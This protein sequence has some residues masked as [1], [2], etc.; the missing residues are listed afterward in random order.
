MAPYAYLVAH[1]GP[2]E[3]SGLIADVVLDG[4]GIYLAAGTPDVAIR[5][6]L[7]HASVPGLPV[8]LVSGFAVEVSPEEL[9]ASGVHSVLA[10][11]INIKAVLEV[12]SAMRPRPTPGGA[13]P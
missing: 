4:A 2:P 8:I 3:P 13:P 10:K 5:V 7:G 11:P 9:Q 1:A 12:A 6:R